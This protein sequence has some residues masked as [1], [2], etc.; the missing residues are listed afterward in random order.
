M[1][2][3]ENERQRMEVDE[4]VLEIQPSS[5]EAESVEEQQAARVEVQGPNRRA[6]IRVASAENA[7]P[8]S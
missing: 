4:V 7:R 5:N 8:C 2:L 6:V 1:G 3:A